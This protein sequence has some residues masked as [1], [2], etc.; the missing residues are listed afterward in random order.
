MSAEAFGAWNKK[1]DFKPRVVAKAQD[2]RDKI[3]KRLKASFL[4]QSLS[5][6]DFEIVVDAMEEKKFA[7]GEYV[8]KQ[9]EDG[10]ELFVVESGVLSCTK[11]FKG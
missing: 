5:D 3:S 1:S 6:R 10:S 9:G 8:I 7:P 4:F 2:T 11:L